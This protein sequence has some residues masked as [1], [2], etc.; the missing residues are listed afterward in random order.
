MP[1]SATIQVMPGARWN[2]LIRWLLV[3]P[4]ITALGV[5]VTTLSRGAFPGESVR[6]LVQ[7][8]G[9]APRL[10]VDRPLWTVLMAALSRLPADDFAIWF[11]L[12][13]ALFGAIAV[14][15]CSRLVTHF[16]HD[17]IPVYVHRQHPGT[18]AL[19]TLFSGWCAGFFLAFA[20]PFWIA[21]T[22]AHPLT[23]HVAGLL[24][25]ATLL[26][27][28]VRRPTDGRLFCLLFLYGLGCV[29]FS[30]FIVFAPMVGIFV[31]LFLWLRDRL[32]VLRIL[33]M[34]VAGLTGLSLYLFAAWMAMRTEGYALRDFQGF[35]HVIW[36]Y[37][38]DQYRFITRGLPQHGWMLMLIVTAI[39]WLIG[40]FTVK[41]A[42]A[43]DKQKAFRLLYLVLTG[44]TLMVL[45]NHSIAPWSLLG[46]RRLL[47][48]PY[49]LSASLFGIL[50]AAWIL[51]P[52]YCFVN[53][54]R[55]W[56][57][58]VRRFGGL[59]PAVL[60][61]AVVVWAPFRNLTVADGRPAEVVTHYAEYIV[62]S[63]AGREWLL[64]DGTLDDHI[65]IAAHTSG[66]SLKLLDLSSGHSEV[67]QRYL[68][69]H[70]ESM[71][72]RGLLRLGLQPFLREW[73]RT[74]GI[75]NRVAMLTMPDLW[76]AAD[77]TVVPHR[78]VF[79]GAREDQLPDADRVWAEHTVFWDEIQP[80]LQ[81]YRALDTALW[82]HT[83]AQFLRHTALSANNLGVFMEDIGRPD[84][85]W[86][87]YRRARDLYENNISALLNLSILTMHD[88]LL[89]EHVIAETRADMARL[90]ESLG[91]HRFQIRRLSQ[92]HGY[93]RMPH[94]F[95][96][97]GWTWALSGNPGM[98]VTSLKRAL[99][100]SEDMPGV[101]SALAGVYLGMEQDIQ[102]EAVYRQILEQNPDDPRALIGLARVA[103]MRRH[104]DV[105]SEYVTAAEEAG[106]PPAQI[107]FERAM[108][109][110]LTGDDDGAREQLY[111]LVE[112]QPDH[113][114]AWV[115]M[116]Y[117]VIRQDDAT[118]LERIL[119][120]LAPLAA[121]D[122]AAALALG[123]IALVRGDMAQA[124]DYFER[125]LRL[126]PGNTFALE[127][128]IRHDL[129]EAR[130][131][132]AEHYVGRLLSI[133]SD[134]A[135][136]NYVLGILQARS[137]QYHLAE[138]A[139]RQS[140]ARQRTPYAL[141]DL[142]NVL[143]E[144]RRATDAE[145]Y[146][147]EAVAMAP[148]SYQTHRTLGRVLL[149]LGR[150]PEA[151]DVLEMALSLNMDDVDAAIDLAEALM[152]AGEIGRASN[153]ISQLLQPDSPATVSQRERLTAL[154]SAIRRAGDNP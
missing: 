97:M 110:L 146:A 95:A 133:D 93:V 12:S 36:I 109:M 147:R 80:L 116:A 113:S 22:R 24:A 118:A 137:H 41:R 78:L 63:A 54:E 107:L 138:S 49:L 29:E 89:P 120:R 96:D 48:T 82:S 5:Y 64:T 50:V 21:A 65:L 103:L 67:Y 112:R 81:S 23:M 91:E 32:S 140:I 37:L 28:Y 85:A 30:T 72:L 69:G 20:N 46:M 56:K 150:F 76:L 125:A 8:I 148:D 59:A 57:R 106:V 101:R 44:L 130:F 134:H 58:A 33:L 4:A 47:V 66:Q 100:L 40:V 42:M 126:R 31:V 6:L 99:D 124:R 16:T 149:H 87:V 154:Q 102:S 152:H 84:L 74:P 135:F 61:L 35:W 70:F 60:S 139:F 119:D 105:A 53:A 71:R 68:A 39:P 26:L 141:N 86:Q 10:Y 111:D 104:F 114:R 79:R 27:S 55:G 128:L 13:S 17:A 45:F 94:A 117:I 121:N 38:G 143:I 62:D 153:Q 34:T 142:A 90:A 51:L 75:E 7:A 122:P 145:K 52:L 127:Q 92:V 77:F 136:G 2:A 108:I 151:V 88:D 144:R 129:R 14:Y 1:E 73:L 9:L 83:A 43:G 132:R 18:V 11:N 3:L 15:L 98:A 123:D 19:A 115:L 131:D 25:V